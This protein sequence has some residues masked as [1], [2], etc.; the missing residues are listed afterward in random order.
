MSPNEHYFHDRA[1]IDHRLD[2]WSDDE[3]TALYEPRHLYSLR[4]MQPK[5]RATARAAAPPIV[6]DEFALPEILEEYDVEPTY[7]TR[8]VA[9]GA[10]QPA[11]RAA[12]QQ[13][14]TRKHSTQPW[15]AP[16]VSTWPA[17]APPSSQGARLRV[18]PAQTYTPAR[19]APSAS[20]QLQNRPPARPVLP[21]HDFDEEDN[22]FARP[23][24]S[25]SLWLRTTAAAAGLF[26]AVLFG[27]VLLD[28]SNAPNTQIPMPLSAA[29]LDATQAPSLEAPKAPEPLAA[30]SVATSLQPFAAT[31]ERSNERPTKHARRSRTTREHNADASQARAEARPRQPKARSYEPTTAPAPAEERESKPASSTPAM[32]RINSRP[33]SQ[34]FIDGKLFGNTPQLGIQLSAG[35]H[36][37]RLVNSEFGMSKTI[38]LKLAAGESVTR[39]EMLSE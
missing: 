21:E 4:Q 7:P 27:R 19:A 35:K 17:A 9:R 25:S 12:P 29:A 15:P 8:G 11:R 34:V 22:P 39:V 24:L 14:N 5:P 30:A 36:S 18:V 13:R 3:T 23:S 31:N 20:R 10:A 2:P 1:S 28:T 38:T 32:L 33:W 16:A 37:V 6:R 26:G